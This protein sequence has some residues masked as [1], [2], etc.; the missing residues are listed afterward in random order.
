MQRG[1]ESRPVGVRVADLALRLKLPT[2]AN[3]TNPGRG[4]VLALAAVAV[5]VALV[6]GGWLLNSRPH[7]IPVASV[8][9]VVSGPVSGGSVSGGPLSG[10]ASPV[11][12]ASQPAGGSPSPAAGGGPVVDVAGKVRHPGV[13]RLPPGARV[14]DAVTAAGGMLPG[15]DPASV[16]LARRLTDGEQVVIGQPPAVGAPA[17][18]GTASGGTAA[19]GAGTA[20]SPVDLN[21]ATVAQLDAL[22]GVGPVLAQRI[23]DWRTEHGRFDTVNDLSKVSGIGE[24]KLTDLKPLVTVS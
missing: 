23:V 12:P 4:G 17:S 22:P 13:Y 16:N 7:S 2:L 10:G 3:R 1:A 24:A 5:L 20:D 8:D 15:V 18:G 6:M 21:T 19:G 14:Q 11:A 9:S